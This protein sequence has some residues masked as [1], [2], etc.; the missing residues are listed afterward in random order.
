MSHALDTAAQV[1]PSNERDAEQMAELISA[2]QSI[3][4]DAARF[5]FLAQP[6]VEA[7][8]PYS[9]EMKMSPLPPG[10]IRVDLS[11]FDCVS[12]VYFL[13]SLYCA[14]NMDAFLWALKSIKYRN[15]CVSSDNQIHFINNSM[16]RTLEANIAVDITDKLVSPSAMRTRTVERLGVKGDGKPAYRVHTV[17]EFFQGNGHLISGDTNLG[18]TVSIRYIHHSAVSEIEPLLKCGDMLFMISAH[19]PEYTPLLF[20]HMGF[21][22]RFE[23]SL[24][25]TFLLHCSATEWSVVRGDR[26]GVCIAR[27]PEWSRQS[28]RKTGRYCELH[29]YF[30]A[31][32]RF[33]D[34]LVVFRPRTLSI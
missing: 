23:D 7:A 2:A 8:A 5:R 27:F 29:E 17:P 11:S 1:Q 3:V 34:G 33:F 28:L 31:Y 18:E 9:R 6:F 19:N 21:A 10:I 14:T 26:S 30:E 12:F 16:A 25:K 20:T 32:K 24:D 13:T 4:D 22:Y 15:S